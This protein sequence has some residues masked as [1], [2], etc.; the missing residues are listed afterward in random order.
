MGHLR[1][2]NLAQATGDGLSFVELG[3]HSA[4]AARLLRGF[5]RWRGIVDEERR[6]RRGGWGRRPAGTRR[7]RRRGRRGLRGLTGL[8]SD[9]GHYFFR[10]LSFGV[11]YYTVGEVLLGVLAKVTEYLVESLDELGL[12]RVPEDGARSAT[13]SLTQRLEGQGRDKVVDTLLFE[14]LQ[15]TV[16]EELRRP[17]ALLHMLPWPVVDSDPG[18]DKGAL[19]DGGEVVVELGGPVRLLYSTD[20]ADGIADW[21]EEVLVH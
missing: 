19:S 18:K 7:R 8:A 10:G 12:L 21:F 1:L 9:L 20:T 5:T 11:P 13:L 14:L 15:D 3:E 4:E 16:P 2:V 6:G 17:Q